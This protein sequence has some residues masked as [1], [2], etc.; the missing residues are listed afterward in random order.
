MY[1]HVSGYAYGHV[2]GHVRMR[3]RR[4]LGRCP[5]Q[6]PVSALRPQ[7]HSRVMPTA[8]A[9]GLDRIGGSHRR[10]LRRLFRYFRIGTH[11]RRSPSACSKRLKKKRSYRYLEQSAV[12]APRSR[13]M[14]CKL[15]QPSAVFFFNISE[16]ADGT[17]R[18]HV[19]VLRYVKTRLTE[20]FPVPP[21]GLI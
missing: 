8:N 9:E 5:E 11:P 14:R 2:Y 4:H 7:P 12:S 16:Q 18:G 19:S 20:T 13:L 6:S 21:S 1:G 15:R 17:R 10:G 3:V